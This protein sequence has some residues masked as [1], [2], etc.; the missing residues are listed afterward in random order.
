MHK[1]KVMGK[2]FDGNTGVSRIAIAFKVC[3]PNVWGR[4]DK[5]SQITDHAFLMNIWLDTC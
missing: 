4:Y 2:A 5:A 3:R 1:A